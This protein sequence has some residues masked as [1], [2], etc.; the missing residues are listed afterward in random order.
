[1]KRNI[2]SR[3][4]GKPENAG[5]SRGLFRTHIQLDQYEL[6]DRLKMTKKKD[7]SFWVHSYRNSE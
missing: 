4:A 5:Y 3:K 1:M 6:D 2:L 7:V